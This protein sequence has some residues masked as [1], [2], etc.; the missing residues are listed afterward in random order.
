[1]FN[2]IFC[3]RNKRTI[4]RFVYCAR[5]KH[6]LMVT[7]RSSFE[8]YIKFQHIFIFNK[9]HLIMKGFT[10]EKTVFLCCAFSVVV[11]FA[12]AQGLTAKNDTLR[13]GPLQTVRKDIIH[14]DFIPGDTYSWKL[15]VFPTSAQGT[16]TT[17]GDYLSF[18]PAA[19]FSGKIDLQ[20]EL[21]G[22]GAT[23]VAGITVIVSQYNSPVNMIDPD[24]ECYSY[25][26]KDIIFDCNPKY[27]TSP[28]A[29]SENW[30]DAFTSPLVGDLNGD[31]KPEIV[32]MGL[33]DET[34]S[35][36]LDAKGRYINIYNGQNG[37]RICRFDFTALGDG[38]ELMDLTNS[39][40]YFY[41]RAPASLALADLDNDGLGEIV[42]CHT[43]TG[44][45]AALK[46]TLNGAGAI[47]GLTR[48][49]EGK[50]QTG[51]I[52]SFKSPQT[53]SVAVF[54][55]PNPYI[56][57]LNGDGIPEVIVYNKIYN[58]KT[59]HL[60]MAWQGAAAESSPK[61]SS[62]TSI[63][64]LSDQ[65][66]T[67]P[68]NS[69]NADNIKGKAMTGRRT[70]SGS[71][72]DQPIAVPAIADID[73]DRK[74]EIITGNRIHKFT[75]NSLTDHTQNTYYTIEGP[76]SVTVPEAG[77]N[78]TYYLSDGFTRVA[79]ID[80]DGTLDIVVEAFGN[81]SGAIY[82]H[83]K[84]VVFVWDAVT[85]NSVKA[86]V[87][88]MST[89]T[90]NA[91][92]SIPFIGDIN[93]KLDG[94]DGGNWTRK[95]PE[96]CI[97]GGGMYINRTN[98]Y[99]N[100]TGISIHPQSSGL[101]GNFNKKP[102]G[103]H[104]IGLTWDASAME[105]W[106]KLKVSW[107]MEHAD[108]STAT[109]ITLFD[110]DNNNTA[111]LC[112]RD[113]QTLRIISPAK[114][115]KDYVTLSET[116]MDSNSSVMIRITNVFCGTGFEYPV[117]ADV[118]MD[119]SADI[120]VTNTGELSSSKTRGYVSVFEYKGQKWA[121]CPPVWNQ[122]MYDPTQVRE[123]LKINAHPVSM[124]TEFEKNGETIRPY[125]GSW[126]QV[127]V[128]REG[129]DFV[130]V[131]RKPNA[132][133]T[134]MTVAVINATTTKVILTI[135]NNGS[136]S[137]SAST[138]I[139]FY[140]GG[141]DGKDINNGATT[142]T[143]PTQA[144]GVDIFPDEKVT[145]EYT[146]SG[147]FNNHLIW[148][149][150]MDDGSKI[151]PANGYD[152][153]DITN[154]TISGIDCPYLKYTVTASPDSV[155]CG[156]ADN[157]LLTATPKDA[158]HY[159]I[160]TYQ[161]YRND[162]LISG[163]TL[164][165]YTATLTGEYK[166][167]V[168]DNICRGFSTVKT[169]T[170]NIPTA[171]DDY[172][173]V[174]GIPTIINV[175]QND[176]KSQYCSVSPAI[177]SGDE[178]KNGTAVVQ[179]DGSILYTPNPVTAETK[180]SIKYTIADSKATVYITLLPI[181]QAILIKPEKTD[182][183]VCSGSIFDFKGSYS[184]DGTFGAS[185]YYRWEHNITGD[186]N[187]QADWIVVGTQK[188]PLASP[189]TDASHNISSVTLADTGYYRLAVADLANI[190]NH[191][192]RALSA[193]V[194]LR[195]TTPVV[196]GKVSG[197]QNICSGDTP[198]QLIS[199]P[200]SGGSG[201]YTYQWQQ[202]D[203][204]DWINVSEGTGGT[205]PNYTPPPLTQTSIYRLK[206][207]GG[208][209]LCETD[210]SDTVAIHID[211]ACVVTDN[212]A[213]SCEAMSVTIPVLKNDILASSCTNSKVKI[214]VP[215]QNGTATVN[216]NN[217]IEYTGNTSGL[218]SLTYIITCGAFVSVPAKVYITVASELAFMDDLWYFGTN[219]QGIRFTN[220]GGVYS[221][222]NASG[223]SKVRSHENSLVV[224]SPYCEGQNLFY[225]S[226]NQL[227][228][229][230]H[231]A[232]NKGNFMGHQSVADG[233]AACYMGNN[234]YLLLSVTNANPPD[235][236]SRGLKSYIVDMNADYGRGA[237]VDST[238]IEAESPDMSE[239]IELI[240][241]D[242]LHKYWLVYAYRVGNSHELRV[243]S[244]DVRSSTPVSAALT[245]TIETSTILS[246]TYTLKASPQ[247]NR[248]AIANSSDKTVDVFD[249]NN[250]TG[251]LSTRRTNFVAIDGN[252][253]GVEFSPDGNQLYAAGYSTDGDTP[254]L[255][256]YK[257]TSGSLDNVDCIQ[258]WTYTGNES[259]DRGG[260]LKLAPD[261][262]IYV[263]LAYDSH[264]GI[265]SNPN[266]T[267]PLSDP[268]RYSSTGMNLG[269]PDYALQ[270]ST[271]LT[272]PSEIECNT[273]T[274]PTTS[275]DETILC[276]SSESRTAK[277]NVIA[278]DPLD[279]EGDTVY[280]TGAEFVDISDTA[281]AY[282]TV[283]PVDSTVSLTVKPDV[284]IGVE[285]HT[286]DIIYH[287]KDNGLPASRCATGKLEVKTYTAPN[288]PDIRVRLC[289]DVGSVNLS[290]YLDT[291]N[292]VKTN[293]IKWTSQIHGMSII[294]PAGTV[295]TD[296]LLYSRIYTFTCA[297]SSLCV[298]G[299]NR[300]VYLEI[301]QNDRDNM[302]K[303]TVVICYR[304]AEAIQIDQLFGIEANGKLSYPSTIDHYV[305]KSLDYNGTVMN[306]KK[307]YENDAVSDYNYHG[308]ANAKKIE[309]KYT[310]DADSCLHSKVYTIVLVLTP[311]IVK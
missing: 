6:Q 243:R 286:F 241:A 46:P 177:A 179:P 219:S 67:A 27:H 253:Y 238:E 43:K 59:G 187:N 308:V 98:N 108:Q 207:I 161:W 261:G 164:Q 201:I 132:I 112:Y 33:N 271:G 240:T 311:D 122:S 20:Y 9:Q 36:A 305:T 23:S 215:P 150:I 31:G 296:N 95:L 57:D 287:V 285:G 85:P 213:A 242:T 22:S 25:M 189:I 121:S 113:E 176:V 134:N 8:L 209:A 199:N 135:R 190:G 256:Q 180:D 107:G 152:D 136:A 208:A 245:H 155:L 304:Y 259:H 228:N 249:F 17:Q 42:M 4:Q 194:R 49:W 167:F 301:L 282:I 65:N 172:I 41:H 37:D 200:P 276:I 131:V 44:R 237:I 295:S 297:T 138:P 183:T 197:N 39:G 123:D 76:Q 283:N 293:S 218:D 103:G 3:Y 2:N 231:E 224:S 205:T 184:D 267:T 102:S 156:T 250:T 154:N 192:C 97:L 72:S 266:A 66:S 30:I 34:G 133:L 299:Q 169:I 86:C 185:L 265:I 111:D 202:K 203:N 175:L 151:I 90:Y 106:E 114:S 71:Y 140:N 144:V 275:P 262:K 55:M 45:I 206:T 141:T 12:Q 171:V 280:L 290:K 28:R 232:M 1:M 7:L 188:G 147:D 309:F 163:A 63:N 61:S 149:Q 143:G 81:E 115:G 120:V 148:A 101:D 160:Q 216:A 84:I 69:A 159:S 54:G 29:S 300:K 129:D 302:I 127:P 191:P 223:E 75:F 225:A 82:S 170:R 26:P 56:A 310:A 15:K 212:A 58:G 193:T 162:V 303:D 10:T 284:Y 16:V 118:N 288:Y 158:P 124:L 137:I 51:A 260:G 204:S 227:Y 11:S 50:D 246:Y 88:F 38:Y 130:P 255:C 195:V 94:Y 105:I 279:T 64:G 278:N 173:T 83:N 35:N 117:I 254:M 116:E 153:C 146:I 234:K 235:A 230:L 294:S 236:S 277:V 291:I 119:G 165:T 70:R 139:A 89:G 251:K 32:I 96:I 248:I 5:K 281:L 53:G 196:S 269:R 258:Y 157:A 40:P 110:F 79:D 168:T 306:G 99:G 272:R 13:T 91:G 198:N 77:G 48:M 298:S 109:G 52:V 229:S 274:A 126:I 92:G 93:G 263:S 270:F 14:N 80:G 142:L 87:S 78:A 60:L 221:A 104:I 222:T 19:G 68:L 210:Y 21:K 73:G 217:E 214:N 292:S 252:A 181:P 273:N 128:V 182:T 264:V 62:Y 226:H 239:S 211:T 47:T 220:S 186:L 18:T 307:I 174:H 257:I 247:H 100:R 125:N 178:P 166:C 289:H 233:L 24:V 74:Q 268:D 244:V 145:M